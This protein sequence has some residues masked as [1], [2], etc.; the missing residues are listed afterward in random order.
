MLIVS[1]TPRSRYPESWK[2]PPP[3]ISSTRATLP[4]S[5]AAFVSVPRASSYVIPELLVF[6]VLGHD[7]LVAAMRVTGPLTLVWWGV[8]VWKALRAAHTF[9]GWLCAAMGVATLLTFGAV[10]A[11][12][13]R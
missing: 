7:A 9:S 8:L 10:T 12:L 1:S 2:T 11:V 5:A 6:G 13:V 3:P 4:S